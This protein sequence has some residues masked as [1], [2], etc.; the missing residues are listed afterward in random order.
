MVFPQYKKSELTP[1][2]PLSTQTPQPAD[3]SRLHY[4]VKNTVP[5]SYDEVL[6][7]ERNPIDL[8]DPSNVKS[9]AE[10][11]PTTGCY[12]VRT[13]IGDREIVTPFILSAD[14]YNSKEIRE[15]MM[16]YYR[17]KNSELYENKG[18]DKFNIFDMK[19]SL[20]PLEKVFG[21][22]G[23]QLKT[24]GSVQVQMGVKS[25]KTDN[26]ALPASARRKTYFDFDQKIQATIDASVGDKLKF[27]M[28][29]NTD[30]TFD[31][32]SKNLKLKY[33]GKEDEIIKSIEAGNVSMT[34]GSSLIKGSTALFGMKT[35]LQFGKLTVTALVSQQNSESQTVNT[36]GGAQKT[37]FSINA[38]E[39]DKN[40]HFFLSHF[41]REH[42][43]EFAS[44]LP[45]V[46]SGINITRIEVWITNTRSSYNES[47][48]I[49]GFMD[50]G[51]NR[52]LQSNHW[53]PDAS[54]AVPSNSSNNLINEIKTGYPDAR[55]ISS[56]T[57]ALEPLS[58]VGIEGG[59]DF[60]KIESARLLT[61]SEYKLNASL[62]YISLTSA[63][64]ADE[65]LC[66]AY[67]YTYQGKNY[68][69]GEFSSD[70]TDTS[71]SLYLKLLKG[72][73][74]SPQ[75]ANWR[76]MM[77]NVYSLGAY[78][79]Q[80]QNFKLNIKYLNDTTG[81]AVQYL[82][83]E[84]IRSTPLLRVMNLDRLDSNNETNPDGF[85]DFLEGYTVVASQ[86]K[87]IFPVAEPFGSYLESKIADPDDAKKYVYKELYD[88]T[89]TVAK[90]FQDKNK[91][92]L[93]GEYQASSG[94]QIR[95]NAMNVPR[96]SVVVTAGGVTLTENSDYT[97][98][99]NMGIVTITN[100]SII[101]SGTNISVSLENQSLYSMQ[102]KTLL[103]LDLNYAFNKDFNIGGT[104]MHFS[105]KPLTEK[106]NIG[107]ELI[108]NTIWG[109]NMSYNKNFMWL[110]NLVNKIPT[111][112]A[113]APSTL[114]VQGE[115]AQLVPHKQKT[116]TNSG[117]SFID[118]FETSQNTIDI[119]SPYSWFLA[120]TPY[121]ASADA[122]FPEAAL[123]NNIDYGKN[124]ALLAWYYVD[125][126]FTQKNSSL[127]PAYLK[128]DLRQMSSPY[129]REV[130][131]KE[132]WPNRE[133][134]YGEASAI[135]TLNLSFY[136]TERGP[137][138][139]DDTNIDA[140][141]NLLNPERRWGG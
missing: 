51:E 70:V 108:N 89:Q 95:L 22:G 26:P 131:T 64:N 106:V 80:K 133:L 128:N 66:V 86:G 27:N 33:E 118:D 127:C 85:Y 84:P 90:Q 1:P 5:T 28:T 29:Y 107:D 54:V 126:M 113:T 46:S 122:L 99:Y 2:P 9:E 32:D 44:K 45:Y 96:G 79:V 16:E 71:Q 94:S 47:R 24:Q 136:P 139:L 25:N 56:V 63:L 60:E 93:E 68:K 30:A 83:V 20:G 115:F 6:S 8:R 43:D 41:F 62:G 31:F 55:Y 104:L 75:F 103:G 15:S 121:D 12:V 132:I 114:S 48:N 78:Q 19:F 77:K 130:T 7:P 123:S 39:Y 117:S 21:P 124:R 10:Y 82:P 53:T 76:L 40:R 137:Y 134:N 59:R 13:R 100:Q 73:T 14:E 34:T 88:S 74:V 49:V 141:F 69:V 116:G 18:K 38:D 23:V 65:I 87:I 111:V 98:D 42:Y 119:R 58:A 110:T 138:N 129:I 81:T 125:R 52:V 112:N 17:K 37:A 92:I 135:Q 97:V 36:K 11:D 35:K 4:K 140:D 105:E 72:A 57:S 101:D 3:S 50:L 120:S 91:F 109:M 67:E 61:S 102:R